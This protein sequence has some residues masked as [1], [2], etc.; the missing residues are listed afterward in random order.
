[1]FVVSRPWCNGLFNINSRSKDFGAAFRDEAV[2]TPRLKGFAV[3]ERAPYA[4]LDWS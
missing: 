4:K 1:L 3:G 2:V